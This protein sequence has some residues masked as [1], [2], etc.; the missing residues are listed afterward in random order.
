MKTIRNGGRRA[1]PA[2]TRP[3]ERERRGSS[4]AA[5]PRR[6]SV[7]AVEVR[8]PWLE[9]ERRLAA[10]SARRLRDH[11]PNFLVVAPPKTATSWV[12]EILSTD[13]RFFMP[14]KECR[15]FSHFWRE[16]PL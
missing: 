6:G 16:Y 1:R 13:R 7:S 3:K 11:A 4:A 15:Y 5:A 10:K 8:A 2:D 14:E 12:Y 9:Y